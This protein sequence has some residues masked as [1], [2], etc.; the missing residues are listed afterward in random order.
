MR[1]GIELFLRRA[2][3][4]L[5]LPQQRFTSEFGKGS[6]WFHRAIDTRKDCWV[7]DPEDCKQRESAIN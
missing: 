4:K 2:T 1:P 5:S 3:P 6:V 7:Q